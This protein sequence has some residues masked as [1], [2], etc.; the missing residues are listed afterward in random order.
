LIRALFCCQIS[1]S[2]TCL[3]MIAVNHLFSLTRMR[4]L[5]SIPT[6]SLFAFCINSSIIFSHIGRSSPVINVYCIIICN[7]LHYN[8][9]S[10]RIKYLFI[11]YIINLFKT[12]IPKKILIILSQKSLVISF[13]K[14]INCFR[15]QFVH[16]HGSKS[17]I[18]FVESSLK[19][20]TTRQQAQSLR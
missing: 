15:T 4:L 2:I 17:C 13:F 7:C 10:W 18:E 8:I 3:S 9:I 16:K 5:L 14:L 6:S 12:Q 19:L 20:K 1:I 11:E